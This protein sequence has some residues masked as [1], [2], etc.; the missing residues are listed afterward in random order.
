MVLYDVITEQ[1][2]RAMA[3]IAE[4][5]VVMENEGLLREGSRTPLINNI[6]EIILGAIFIK[7]YAW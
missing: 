3:A 6:I 1:L 4:K 2:D 5:L 7:M